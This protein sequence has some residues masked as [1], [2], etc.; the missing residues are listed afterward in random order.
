M[1]RGLFILLCMTAVLSSVGE[2]A[3]IT[4]NFTAIA[5][6]GTP[7]S[8]TLAFDPDSFT[9]PPFTPSGSVYLDTF[10]GG[11][12]SV[13]LQLNEGPI[14]VDLSADNSQVLICSGC[15]LAWDLTATFGQSSLSIALNSLFPITYAPG[16]SIFYPGD[17]LNGASTLDAMLTDPDTTLNFSIETISADPSAPEPASFWTAGLGVGAL[18]F[19]RLLAT[20][21]L[22]KTTIRKP[23]A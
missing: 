23:A 5:N 8:G 10:T 3:Q 15:N 19:A 4:E 1:S 22:T 2:S 17:F 14:G 20:C 12:G 21:R 16:T 13:L 18:L 7:L 6:G 11:A 9:P